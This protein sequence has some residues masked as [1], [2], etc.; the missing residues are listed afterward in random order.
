MQSAREKERG[1]R[2]CGSSWGCSV[3]QLHFVRDREGVER[4]GSLGICQAFNFQLLQQKF[5]DVL[6]K[7]AGE[8]N[9]SC[10]KRLLQFLVC[11]C[12]CFFFFFCNTYYVWH[13]AKC[14]ASNVASLVVRAYARLPGLNLAGLNLFA[15][16]H[17]HPF[18]RSCPALFLR[19]AFLIF[20]CNNF[21]ACNFIFG[22][23][24]M[25]PRAAL[26]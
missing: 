15:F 4:R 23:F 9:D 16:P 26:V 10:C 18:C 12:C 21:L 20:K 11:C 13:A 3:S 7:G 5:F 24:A 19:T 22:Y 14:L 1:V 2:G 8:C 6:H 25:R 17:L